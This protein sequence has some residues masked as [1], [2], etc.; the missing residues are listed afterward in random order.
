MYA[1]W[2]ACITNCGSTD[3]LEDLTCGS[4]VWLFLSI[5][6]SEEKMI[7]KVIGSF[8]AFCGKSLFWRSI[9]HHAVGWS[10]LNFQKNWLSH[11]ISFSPCSA[12]AFWG[13]H[14]WDKHNFHLGISWSKS[15]WLNLFF[16][17]MTRIA[18]KP[19]Q[20]LH[21]FVW[22]WSHLITDSSACS[23]SCTSFPINQK[24]FTR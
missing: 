7:C 19:N 14:S 5:E 3:L 21:C 8:F 6:F 4:L 17:E 2:F 15:D 1:W 23:S 18:R 20:R 12:N 10:Y 16:E 24:L 13:G 11:R 22:W 9:I